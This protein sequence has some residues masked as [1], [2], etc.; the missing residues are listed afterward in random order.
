[1]KYV[2]ILLTMAAGFLFLPWWATY[3]LA[4][5]ML[6]FSMGYIPLIFTIL[7][8]F[9]AL[10]QEFPYAS[11]VFLGCMLVAYFIKDQMFDGVV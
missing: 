10:P 4:V 6:I 2:I 5:V 11:V 8:D 7:L 9:F 3:A 1:M